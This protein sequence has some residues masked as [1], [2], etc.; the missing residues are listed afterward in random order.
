MKQSKKDTLES[1]TLALCVI[2]KNWT[3]K[4]ETMKK[5]INRVILIV[6]DSVGI[7]A[8]PDA[9]LYGDEGSNT[10]LNIYKHLPGFKLENLELFGLSHIE[11]L[12]EIRYNDIAPL[13][14]YGRL[15]ELSPGK[16]TTTGH[17]EIAGLVLEQPFPTYPQGFPDDFM[18]QFTQAVHRGYLANY[19]ASGTEIIQV[20]GEEHMKTG[21]LIVYTSADSV[22][23]IAAHEEVVSLDELYDICE[24]ARKLLTGEHAVGRVIA[25]PFIGQPGDFQRTKNRKDYSLKPNGKTFLDYIEQAGQDVIGIGKISDI[26]AGQGIT[27]SSPTKNNDDGIKETLRRINQPSKGLIFTNLVDFDM[28]FGHRNDVAGYGKA[29]QD[30][31]QHLMT[32]VDAMKEDDL[33]M[34]TADHGCDPTTSSTDHSREYVPL[35][36]YHPQLKP[37]SLGT[38]RGFN[39]I[40]STVL[41]FL[42][43]SHHLEGHSLKQVLIKE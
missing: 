28:L 7:G 2:I 19:P 35:L 34:I 32:I 14:S 11:G 12:H 8:M 9:Y 20:F 21:K 27:Q 26:F 30:F 23:Q 3:D 39:S 4:E 31:D 15:E 33:L 17:W 18:H 37:K 25:R 42:N 41:D 29:L 40:A 6:L 24:K 38:I 1:K 22:F 43:I 13:A 16:D 10:L 36:V 5:D